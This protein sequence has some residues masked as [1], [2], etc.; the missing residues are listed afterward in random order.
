MREFF[1]RAA[2]WVN[3]ERQGLQFISAFG[4]MPGVS[5]TIER[6]VPNSVSLHYTPDENLRLNGQ[7]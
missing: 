6:K 5:I 2:E 3:K 1:A 7:M 4:E